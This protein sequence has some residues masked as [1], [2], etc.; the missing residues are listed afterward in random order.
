MS[1]GKN[2]RVHVPFF[3]RGQRQ[4]EEWPLPLPVGPARLPAGRISGERERERGADGAGVG[5]VNYAAAA[6]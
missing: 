6:A 1:A 5:L 3:V 4:R 2:A